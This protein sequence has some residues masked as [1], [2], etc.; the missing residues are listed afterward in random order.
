MDPY[1]EVD[2]FPDL[3]GAVSWTM[4]RL[5]PEASPCRTGSSLPAMCSLNRGIADSANKTQ[6]QGILFSLHEL[7]LCK[8]LYC[9]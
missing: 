3:Y 6:L 5:F 2:L 4:D 1:T 9:I 7:G 8:G